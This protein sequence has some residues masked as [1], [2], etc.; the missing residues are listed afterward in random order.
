MYV[1]YHFPGWKM[2][3]IRILMLSCVNWA[4]ARLMRR[5]LIRNWRCS[6]LHHVA[7]VALLLIDEFV[8]GCVRDRGQSKEEA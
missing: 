3:M 1:E 5:K 4:F 2:L 8:R 6:D 7:C